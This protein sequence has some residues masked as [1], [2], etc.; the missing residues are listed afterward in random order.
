MSVSSSEKEQCTGLKRWEPK[1]RDRLYL[2]LAF[3]PIYVWQG[4]TGEFSRYD[5]D[6]PRELWWSTT[7]KIDRN[8]SYFLWWIY[9]H[10]G[11]MISSHNK[12]GLKS[13]AVLHAD[14]LLWK[15]HSHSN[16]KTWMVF[17]LTQSD[18]GCLS[19]YCSMIISSN[20]ESGIHRRGKKC[21]LTTMFSVTFQASLGLG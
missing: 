13:G 18:E 12:N 7:K 3:H 19:L 17:R 1:P 16:T 14:V 9:L 10:L 11:D 2:L 8:C 4:V 5:T 21:Q 15:V 20:I 6:R